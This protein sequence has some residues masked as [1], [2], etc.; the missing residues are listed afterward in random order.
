MARSTTGGTRL[1]D[2]EGLQSVVSPSS[3]LSAEEEVAVGSTS[4]QVRAGHHA[5]LR[6]SCF[7]SPQ[8]GGGGKKTESTPRMTRNPQTENDVNEEGETI[9]KEGGGRGEKG[10][11]PRRER[12]RERDGP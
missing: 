6:R 4:V 12:E 2:G 3:T 11:E 1:S 5:A 7:A 10:E 8:R 9:E